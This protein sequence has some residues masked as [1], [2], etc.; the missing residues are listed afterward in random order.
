MWPRASASAASGSNTGKGADFLLLVLLLPLLLLLLLLGLLLLLLLVVLV[1]LVVL[2]L[3]LLLLLWEGAELGDSRSPA[4][5]CAC[6]G[7]G[8]SSASRSAP[9]CSSLYPRLHHSGLTT[10]SRVA[11]QLSSGSSTMATCTQLAMISQGSLLS[12]AQSP[13]CM[14]TYTL[15]ADIR[16]TAQQVLRM[17]GVRQ[18]VTH[19]TCYA[20]GL[21][22]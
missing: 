10:S 4:A 19:P 20:P 2:V 6:C 17:L 5:A 1:V 22:L 9:A 3:L 14:Y 12:Q 21:G 7:L 11:V 8:C 13:L 18:Q 16:P 15:C